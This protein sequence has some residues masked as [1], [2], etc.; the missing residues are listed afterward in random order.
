MRIVQKQCTPKC[1]KPNNVKYYSVVRGAVKII[2]GF[3]RHNTV[4]SHPYYYVKARWIPIGFKLLLLIFFTMMAAKNTSNKIDHQF[5]IDV[6]T[7]YKAA[8]DTK[9]GV[10]CPEYFEETGE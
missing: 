3:F 4:L 8:S 1:S 5:P 2:I 9:Y 10:D 6:K 7:I